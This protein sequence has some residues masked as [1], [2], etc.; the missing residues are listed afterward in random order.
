VGV[1][2]AHAFKLA[3]PPFAPFHHRLDMQS[4]P[5]IDTMTH[6]DWLNMMRFPPEWTE[7]GLI[8]DALAA[9]Q[10]AGYAPG[11]ENASEHDRHGAFQWWLERAPSPATESPRVS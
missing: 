11:H 7:W 9:I 10:L 4:D 8:P 6:T 1:K 3:K 2:P 5:I